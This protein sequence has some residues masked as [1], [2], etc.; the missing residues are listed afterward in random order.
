MAP[1]VKISQA[2]GIEL[3]C[4]RGQTPHDEEE[5]EG[6]LL[7]TVTTRGDLDEVEQEAVSLSQLTHLGLLSIMTDRET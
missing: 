5:K 1:L 2:M 7:E 3:Q 4:D 6:L